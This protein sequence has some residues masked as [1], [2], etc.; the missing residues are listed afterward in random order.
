MRI[1]KITN[2]I[3]RIN[4]V[5]RQGRDGPNQSQWYSKMASSQQQEGATTIPRFLQFLQEIRKGLQQNHKTND[6]INR[7]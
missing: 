5:R 6:S 2:R 7:K 1:R 4:R 3:F